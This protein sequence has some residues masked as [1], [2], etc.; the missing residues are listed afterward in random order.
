MKNVLS[1]NRHDK[2]RAV[3]SHA[4]DER[5]DTPGGEGAITQ[6]TQID[7]GVVHAQF[8]PHEKYQ[9][10]DAQKGHSLDKGR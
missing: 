5:D 2:N 9:R 3:K 4:D 6:H 1:K 8:L 7:C 10:T